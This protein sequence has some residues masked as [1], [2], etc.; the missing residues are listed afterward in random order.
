MWFL[1]GLY[2][3]YYVILPLVLLSLVW[4]I[5]Q[6]QKSI[7]GII[8]FGSRRKSGSEMQDR[9]SEMKKLQV[10]LV[11]FLLLFMPITHI[12]SF[13]IQD[14]TMKYDRIATGGL[15]GSIE[16]PQ[17]EKQLGPSFD[18]D[19]IISQMETYLFS[20]DSSDFR[21]EEGPVS[22]DMIAV[23]EDEGYTISER[24]NLTEEDDV[25]WIVQDGDRKFRIEES[26][27][28]LEVYERPP[29]HRNWFIEGV[30][31]DVDL[32]SLTRIPGRLGV[33]HL[34]K[35]DAGEFLV[36]TYSYLS[37]LPITRTFIFLVVNE[38]AS[39]Y[40]ERTIVYPSDPSD[41]DL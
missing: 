4:K 32:E 40:Q 15:G 8:D 30:R 11:I 35:R 6:K 27:D 1:L 2:F 12:I 25:W 41:I 39:L 34:N 31:E 29:S 13:Q 37:P 19:S 10:Y 23:F 26:E 18:T 24:S 28:R 14:L 7:Q 22:E 38:E 16:Y 17:I 9:V 3:V 36:I 20:L 33:Y 5:W 21:L